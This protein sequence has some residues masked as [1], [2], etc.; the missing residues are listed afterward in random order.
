MAVS[1]KMKRNEYT[2]FNQN[3]RRSFKWSNDNNCNRQP[4]ANTVRMQIQ[5]SK[6]FHSPD[7]MLFQY[8][9]FGI[10]LQDPFLGIPFYSVTQYNIKSVFNSMKK[11]SIWT[12]CTSAINQG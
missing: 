6:L 8:Y 3:A 12:L 1:L 4:H 11:L 9:I 5:F 2:H 7:T 10:Y